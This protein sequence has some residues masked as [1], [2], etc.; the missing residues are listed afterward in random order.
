VRADSPGNS[1]FFRSYLVNSQRFAT[2]MGKWDL[3]IPFIELSMTIL[4]ERGKSSLII[5]DSYCHANYSQASL[6]WLKENRYLYKIDYFP[7]IDVFEN[8]GVKSVIINSSKEINS[9]YVQR[10]FSS[11]V[12]YSESVYASYP[13]SFRLDSKESLFSKKWEGYT[14]LDDICYISKGIVGNS[15]EKEYQGEFEIGDL[16]SKVQDNLHPKLYFEGKD[17]GKWI[18]LNKRWIEYGTN[19]SPGRWSRKG[20]KSFFE[21]SEKLVAMRSPGYIPRILLDS[22]NG[23]FNESAIGFKRWI[24]LLG[25]DNL[26]IKGVINDK[27]ARANL[28]LK[29]KV[30]DYKYLLCILNSKVIRY[31]LNSDR[32]SNIHIYPEDYKKLLIPEIS[33]ADQKPFVEKCNLMISKSNEF[34]QLKYKFIQLLH[35][36]TEQLSITRKLEDWPS[37]SFKEFLKELNKQKIKLTLQDQ[38]EWMQYFESEKTKMNEIQQI[39]NITEKEINDMIYNLYDLSENDRE[40]IEEKK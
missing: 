39:I 21:G 17:I 16:L 38:S 12:T 20:F 7:E 2:L 4:K 3:Y 15:D 23:Y 34:Q 22:E 37:V 31:E 35:H 26:S 19:R 28:E 27:A 6:N 25:V 24:D 1:M 9:Q 10:V 13:Q 8:V 14:R 36:K 5:P 30:Y 11:P 18:L 32:R 33:P 40:L 29:S